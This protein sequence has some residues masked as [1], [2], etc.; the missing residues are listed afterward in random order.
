MTTTLDLAQA[1][2]QE[3]KRQALTLTDVI[4]KTGVSRAAVYRLS[5]G[6]DVQLTTLLA[7]TNLLGLDLIAVRGTVA[8]LVPEMTTNS[9]LQSKPGR[10][11]TRI[12]PVIGRD[13]RSG[14]F[15]VLSDRRQAP[16]SDGPPSAVSVRAAQLQHRL[17]ALKK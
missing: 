1:L 5:N 12:E 17:N 7:V 14:R 9:G 16:R 13:S 3:C 6:E 15:I 8:K 10:P 2:R 4:K 11:N